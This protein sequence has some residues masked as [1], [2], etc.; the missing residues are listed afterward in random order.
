MHADRGQ[1]QQVLMNLCLNARDAMPN[2]GTLFDRHRMPACCHRHDSRSTRPQAGELPPADG[3]RYRLRDIRGHQG[4]AV[5]AVLYDQGNRQRNRPRPGDGLRD[6]EATSRRNPRHERAQQGSTFEIYLPT[7]LALWLQQS[8]SC[9]LSLESL[10]QPSACERHESGRELSAYPAG[11]RPPSAA[12]RN[13]VR[14]LKFDEN[15]VGPFIAEYKSTIAFAQLSVGDKIAES[16]EI[17]FT[18]IFLMQL[19]PRLL[20]TGGWSGGSQGKGGQRSPNQKRTSS[21]STKA[22]WFVQWPE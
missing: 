15:A 18:P 13:L 21:V 17:E 10:I 11:R 12:R 6:R 14:G 19:G 2:G 4:P 22:L 16:D 3:P 8:A 9:K 1:L 20:E 5:R 7:P